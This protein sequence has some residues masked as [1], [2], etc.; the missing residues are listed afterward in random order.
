MS[1]F[2]ENNAEYFSPP[3]TFCLC[4]AI[5]SE[6]EQSKSLFNIDLHPVNRS[7][8]KNQVLV[9]NLEKDPTRSNM[10]NYFAFLYLLH[11][12]WTFPLH[13]DSKEYQ[14]FPTPSETYTPRRSLHRNTRAV[15]YLQTSLAALLRND[16]KKLSCVVRLI[17]QFIASLLT[18][19]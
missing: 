6:V 15:M 3:V 9:L 13:T 19:I 16:L 1:H 14:L 12:S 4:T 5:G 7:N 11:S 10:V 8:L 2:V 17:F 18:T